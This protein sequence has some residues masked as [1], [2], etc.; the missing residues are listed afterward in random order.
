MQWLHQI[1]TRVDLALTRL[2]SRKE[3]FWEQLFR[4]WP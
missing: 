4:W 1:A 3:G 2:A